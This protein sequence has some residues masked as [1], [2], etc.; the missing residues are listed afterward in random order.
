MPRTSESSRTKRPAYVDGYAKAR[1]LDPHVADNY[2][3]HTR[4]GDPVMDAVVEDLAHL[5][6][7]QVHKFIHAG[8]EEDHGRKEEA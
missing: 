6:Q 3:A 4:I 1:A 2:V 8:M 7:G 5:P